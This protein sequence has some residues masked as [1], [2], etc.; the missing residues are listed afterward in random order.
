[1]YSESVG[2]MFRLKGPWVSEDTG[3]ILHDDGLLVII[4]DPKEI[5]PNNDFP[6]PE[7][8]YW[9]SDIIGENTWMVTPDLLTRV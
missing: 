4:V 9:V 7:G 8:N 1:M 2:D 5:D 3:E 6:L